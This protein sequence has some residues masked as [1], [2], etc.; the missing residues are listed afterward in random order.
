MDMSVSTENQKKVKPEI[1][2]LKS[3]ERDFGQK[4][5]YPASTKTSLPGSGMHGVIRWGA[6]S[7]C[8][9]TDCSEVPATRLSAGMF[10]AYSVS[11]SLFVCE[12]S[13]ATS[14]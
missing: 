5:A 7:V 2:S 6:G 14:F 9:T 11:E 3:L 10:F 8:Q 1:P 4:F 12:D 13:L